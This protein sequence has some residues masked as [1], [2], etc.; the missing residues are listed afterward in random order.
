M[1]RHCLNHGPCEDER[2]GRVDG[3]AD[4]IQFEA[5][6]VADQHQ[7]RADPNRAAV[8]PRTDQEGFDQLQA[9]QQADEYGRC[10]R[11]VR[12]RPRAAGPIRPR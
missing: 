4:A 11:A 6:E 8:E 2:R 7:R 9:D 10:S 1:V 5:D 3:T 12:S